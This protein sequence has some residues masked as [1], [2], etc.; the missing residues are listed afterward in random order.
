M[1]HPD[2]EQA[3]QRI[4]RRTDVPAEIAAECQRWARAY[5]AAGHSGA[6]GTL[7]LVSLV[8]ICGVELPEVQNKSE[9]TVWH[10]LPAGTRVEAHFFGVWQP[11]TF[12]GLAPD[13]A[14]AIRVDG[15]ALVRE[16]RPHVVRLPG[17]AASESA[18]AETKQEAAPASEPGDALGPPEPVDWLAVEPGE[19]VWATDDAGDVC[20]ATFVKVG[21]T[22]D[23]GVETLVVTFDG[24]TQPRELAVALVL[25]AA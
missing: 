14:L 16:C 25:K 4:L 17:E 6:L 13:G 15:D 3:L 12:C 23:K 19:G 5:H 22:S 7:A 20:D 11:G 9:Q 10:N 2:D 8:R 21:K 24:Q 1:I 18:Q